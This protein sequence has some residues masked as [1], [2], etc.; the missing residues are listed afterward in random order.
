MRIGVVGAGLQASRR[1]AAL[2][3]GVVVAAIAD[4]E[5]RRSR[6]LTLRHGGAALGSWPELVGRTDVD[7]VL[8][9][10]P[11]DSHEEISVAALRAG[12]HVLCEKPMALSSGAAGRMGHAAVKASRVLHC[13]FNHR[14]HP[15]VREL[16][17]LIGARTFGQ[18]LSAIGIYG[19]G[20]REGYER[21]WRADP[22]VVSGGQVMEQ[23]IHLVDL[24]D[25]C[26]WPVTE[27]VAHLQHTFG[28]NG[29]EDD[30][31]L[32]LRSATGQVA[33]LRSS[34][35]QWRNRFLL[36]VTCER[37]T[38][39]VNG[40]GGSYGEQTL[41]VE[42]RGDGPFQTAQTSFRGGDSTW[43]SEWEYFTA[44]CAQTPVPCPD[45][46]GHRSLAIVETAYRST[47][48]G[49]WLPI[50]EEIL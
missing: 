24:V 14:F 23:G 39:R 20:F 4:V 1:L 48:T 12:K 16:T 37:A 6:R 3:D 34:L 7:A 40:I 36:E 41:A 10:T 26:L 25:S 21:E 28:L 8:V 47:A 42:Q 31:H 19:Y 30:G 17:R 5:I 27:A 33:Y 15:A 11:P 35:T 46:A 13:G 43:R 18:P 50:I 44:L 2:P 22:A 9:A 45:P 32:L 29:L 49:G 38:L